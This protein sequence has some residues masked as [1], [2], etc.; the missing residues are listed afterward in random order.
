MSFTLKTGMLVVVSLICSA[1]CKSIYCRVNKESRRDLQC[2]TGEL[3]V[4]DITAEVKKMHEADPADREYRKVKGCAREAFY[5]C[6]PADKAALDVETY[7]AEAH[8]Q[9]TIGDF[10]WRCWQIPDPFRP[11]PKPTDGHTVN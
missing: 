5:E 4:E 2:D 6:N 9:R 8:P 3:Q 7:R 10:S 1:C 11:P